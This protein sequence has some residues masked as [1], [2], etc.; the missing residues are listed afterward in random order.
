MEEV[1]SNPAPSGGEDNKE[2]FA[3]VW[4]RVMADGGGQ[5]PIA[6]E[7]PAAKESREGGEEEVCLPAPARQRSAPGPHSDF[8]EREACW[9]RPA[10]AAPICCRRW[11]GGS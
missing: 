11:C 8:P 5:C 4:K 6:W 9:G 7:E 2:I 3:R 1:V 10:W